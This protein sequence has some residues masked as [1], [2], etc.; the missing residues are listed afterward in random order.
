MENKQRDENKLNEDSNECCEGCLCGDT[1]ELLKTTQTAWTL[2]KI[3]NQEF[4]LNSNLIES[5]EETPDTTIT[6]TNDKKIIVKEPS[7]VVVQLIIDYNRK[8]FAN[9]SKR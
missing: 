5:I 9:E 6:L 4:I 7:H 8:I 2:T 3:N 1:I